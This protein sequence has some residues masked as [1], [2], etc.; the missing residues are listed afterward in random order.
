MA[1]VFLTGGSGFIGGALTAALRERGDEVVA[2]A[3][4]AEAAGKVTASGAEPVRGDVLDR[5]SLDAAIVGC[6]LVYH[7]A[8]VNSH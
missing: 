2:L 4:S 6:D 5:S 1:K 7:V 8:G 3:R